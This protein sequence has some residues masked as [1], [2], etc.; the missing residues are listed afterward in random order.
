MWRALVVTFHIAWLAGCACEPVITGTPT[1]LDAL[2]AQ[3]MLPLIETRK[4][5]GAVVAV[6]RG[7]DVRQYA[8]GEKVAGS[9]VA[10]DADT[11][12]EVGSV[13]KTYTGALLALAVAEGRLS[14]ATPVQDLLPA[15]VT[16]P[17]YQG[18]S[19]TLGDLASHVS[20]L[21]R[22]PPN[23][24]PRSLRDP[25]SHY[26]LEHLYAFLNSYTLPRAPGAAYEYSNVGLALLGHL[27]E[28]EAG[29]PYAQLLQSRLLTPLGLE[30]TALTLDE[31]QAERLAAPY[32]VG[33]LH[34]LFCLRPLPAYPWSPGVFTP[35]AALRATL[36]DLVAYVRVQLDARG[37]V[38]APAMALLHTPRVR[39]DDTTWVALAWHVH[40]QANAPDVLWHNGETGGY[41]SFVCFVPERGEAVVI[42]GNTDAS[43]Y[44]KPAALAILEGL[45]SVT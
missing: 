32:A 34:D 7:D 37:T 35:A 9:G 39:V 33:P 31:A 14:L 21:P 18:R 28:R 2:V 4:L 41:C 15:G 1:T 11:F 22:M 30:D 29:V 40:R 38:L 17:T 6:V 8:F 24:Q 5:T 12:F 36:H 23:F 16:S 26:T 25:F 19:I 27:L 44:T 45:Q 20:G 3:Q 13:T 42:L 43:A 10:P